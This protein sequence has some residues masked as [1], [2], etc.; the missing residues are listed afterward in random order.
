MQAPSDVT[1]LGERP[2][3]ARPG[4]GARTM[5]ELFVPHLG[6]MGVGVIWLLLSNAF[7]L[8]VPRLV[9]DG[10]AAATATE[11]PSNSFM[12][13][14][15]VPLRAD[16]GDVRLIAGLIA[17][18][19]VLG[20]VAR[21]ASRVVL[22]NV[23]RDVERA[24]RSDVFAHVATLSPTF[25]RK[26]SVGD[27]MSRLTNDMTNVRLMAGF[28]LLNALNAAIIFVATL[29][30]MFSL[31]AKVAALA[32]LPFPLVLVA[33][34]S[35]SRVMFRRTRENQEA[36]GHLTTAVQENL[37]G[38]Q[39]VR[40]FSREEGE[41]LRFQET[42][43]HVYHAAMRLAHVRLAMG[44]IMGLMGSLAIGVSLYAG[45]QAIVE[46]RLGVGD[47]VEMNAR[48]M[49]L[50]WPTIAMGF[51]LSV[52]QRGKA[53]LS[54]INE[55]LVEVPD[56]V[57][58]A[59]DR[60]VEGR[61][62]A[63]GLSVEVA[64]GRLG[65]DGFDV[66]VEPGKVLGVVGLT[67]SGKS[68]FLRALARQ[69][70]CPRSQL[71]VDGVDVNDW[72]LRALHEGVGV[73]PEDGFLF[74]ATLEENLAF[75][76]PE[77][78]PEEIEGVV[79]LCDLRRDVNSFPEGLKTVVGERG[80]TL[81][82][83]QRQRVA[84]GRAI[85]A[86]PAVLLLDDSLSAVD[87]ETEARVVA[88]LRRGFAPV[89]GAGRGGAR[90]PPTLIVV[91]HRLSA[92]RAAD[93]IVVLDGGRVVERGTHDALL[94]NNGLYADLWGREQLRRALESAQRPGGVGPSEGSP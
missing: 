35:V 31:D 75:G 66:M 37:A 53:S 48:L 20:A 91:S 8:L 4:G 78:T 42:A 47:V 84:L 71:F 69:T 70:P 89:E 22:F 58:G 85:L 81:S 57:D 36:L 40:A 93:E 38:Q 30:L 28:A 73:V 32:L 17:A 50:A 44:P 65:L 11:A 87:A 62:E 5:R 39:V 92:V 26:S 90:R 72:H 55:L 68:T 25:F 82:G 60:P 51:I 7:L 80:V 64:P 12:K 24:L 61:V 79:D 88:A 2:A 54:R 23:G 76:R 67:G 86:R 29:P 33:A 46:G 21:V 56:I 19:A 6:P 83:G 15:G 16:V 59:V 45:G 77:A 34:Q 10:I 9:N 43:D 94:T 74:S 13:L 41:R 49:Q 1:V 27:L 18:A 52:Y 3:S 14:L 63:R